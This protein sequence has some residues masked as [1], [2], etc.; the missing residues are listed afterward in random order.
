MCFSNEPIPE[1]LSERRTLANF[2]KNAPFRHREI[3]QTWVQEIFK[4]GGFEDLIEYDTSVERV[5]KRDAEW[6]LTLRKA[7]PGSDTDAWWQESFDAVVVATGHYNVPSMPP[8]PGLAEF[9]AKFPGRIQ[10]SKHYKT[11]ESYR[12]KHVLVVGGSVSAFDTLHDVRTVSKLPVISSLRRPSPV[13]GPTPFTHPDI[14]NRPAIAALD[15][16]NG[17]VTFTDGTYA[18]GVDHIVF[19]TGY[20][21]SFPFLEDFQPKNGRIPGLYQHVFHDG[22]P[23]LA[24]IGMVTGGFGLRI[25][26]WQSVAMAR[27]FAGRAPLP[28]C[29][30]MKAWEQER[31]VERGDGPSFWVL[32]P[33]FERY[34]EDLR[35][36]AGEP[37]SGTTGRVLPRYDDAWGEAFWR[38]VKWR[39]QLWEKDAADAVALAERATPP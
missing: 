37:A 11:A 33:D 21:F 14:L 29:I 12:D 9:D 10:H 8:I 6:V 17:R 13:F 35:A 15:A 26:E 34:F 27:V 20:E 32:M 18:D 28:S 16:D 39:V 23:S 7:A 2:G 30:E 22:D 36:I 1:V 19:A 31:I 25:F 4:R 38:F 3:M 5:E 24:F